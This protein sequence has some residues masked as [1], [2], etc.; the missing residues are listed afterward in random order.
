[1]ILV[2]LGAPMTLVQEEVNLLVIREI[3]VHPGISMFLMQM[4]QAVSLL[5]DR[6]LTILAL[7]THLRADLTT[8]G[9]ARAETSARVIR[10]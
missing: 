8:L 6:A 4:I 3:L 7:M 9:L 1:M 5:R 2:R 10:M